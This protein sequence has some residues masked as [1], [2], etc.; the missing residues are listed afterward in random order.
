MSPSPIELL[1]HML[2]ECDY[3]SEQTVGLEKESF[4]GDE[5]L[6][7]A[8]VR[9]I[10][11]IGEAAKGLPQESREKRPDVDWRRICGMRDRLIHGYF[12]VDYDIVWDVL[13][14]HIPA[15]QSALSDMISEERAE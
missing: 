13:T 3:V 1:Q 2:D 15:L 4:L 12:A 6:K 9:S 10:E 11:V 7:R 14:N 8:I 5:T